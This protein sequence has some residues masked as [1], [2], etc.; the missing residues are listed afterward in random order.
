MAP[1]G[2][3]CLPA[4]KRTDQAKEALQQTASLKAESQEDLHLAGRVESA[5]HVTGYCAMRN[6]QV[7]V[8]ARVV[9]LAGRLPSYHLKQV[10]QTA[11]QG[12]P[13]IHQII[14]DLEVA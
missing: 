2:L 1:A 3:E 13:G 5:L 4:G 14:N 7:S 9:I 8:Q 11:A 6:L 10:A 12:V